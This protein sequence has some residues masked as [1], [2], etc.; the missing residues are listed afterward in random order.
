MV[1]GRAIFAFQCVAVIMHLS[2][3][4]LC[5]NLSW[6]MYVPLCGHVTVVVYST[7]SPRGSPMAVSV[8]ENC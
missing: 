8:D 2:C 5:V 6:S 4:A 1:W 7:V 3:V